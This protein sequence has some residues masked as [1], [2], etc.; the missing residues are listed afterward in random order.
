[1]HFWFMLHDEI[2]YFVAFPSNVS[3]RWTILIFFFFFEIHSVQCSFWLVYINC[4]NLHLRLNAHFENYNFLKA[5]ELKKIMLRKYY[6]ILW[7]HCIWNQKKKKKATL[8]H[9]WKP[10][11]YCTFHKS[12]AMHEWSNHG[13]LK[14]DIEYTNKTCQL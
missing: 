11:A 12:V 4:Y 1:M 7:I 10:T 8:N 9:Q 6:V 3:F 5:S 14:N 2:K 13:F